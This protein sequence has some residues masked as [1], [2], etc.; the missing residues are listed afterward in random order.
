MTLKDFSKVERDFINLLTKTPKFIFN[1]VEYVTKDFG[2]P[3]PSTGECKTD[4][5]LSGEDAN[6]NLN[7]IKISI[8]KSN[9]DFLEN[10]MSRERAAK[11]FGNDYKDIL[12]SCI[13]SIKESFENEPLVRI[14]KLGRV[15]EKTISLGWKFEIV[16]KSGGNK[17]GT[18]NLTKIQ[19]IDIYAGTNLDTDKKH[20]FIN[21]SRIENSGVAEYLLEINDVTPNLN[22]HLDQLETIEDF[23]AGKEFHFACKALNYRSIKDKWDSDR[24]LAVYVD[25][26]I[27]DNKLLG[28]LVYDEPLDKKGNE[29]GKKLQNALKQLN[30]NADNFK[31]IAN[32]Y[33]GYIH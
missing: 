29:I 4:I 14:N 17:S 23:I 5:Y 15:E 19:K 18:M 27:I 30:I 32:H 8:K 13:Q 24:P 31:D 28:R 26:Q 11:L 1:G 10:K 20:C 2:K 6:G 3:R 9:A 16:N 21:G 22:L 12:K 25:W 7:E 33:D